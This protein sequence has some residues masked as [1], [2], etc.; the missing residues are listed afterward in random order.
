M[1]GRGCVQRRR[2]DVPRVRNEA[3]RRR[4]RLWVKAPVGVKR[5]GAD[6]SIDLST[7]QIDSSIHTYTYV[8]INMYVLYI[9]FPNIKV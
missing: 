9:R 3:C 7:Y 8:C 5:A 6:R 4:R 2:V 1:T